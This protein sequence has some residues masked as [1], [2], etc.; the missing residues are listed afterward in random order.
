[1]NNSSFPSQNFAKAGNTPAYESSFSPMPS[2]ASQ[3]MQ[4]FNARQA[5]PPATSPT[6]M[7]SSRNFQPSHGH[8]QSTSVLLNS[9]SRQMY[10]PQ[11]Q[12]Q[13][14]QNA[15]S[16]NRSTSMRPMSAFQPLDNLDYYAAGGG[17]S[18]PT[19]Q[20]APSPTGSTARS[21]RSTPQTPLTF[22][23]QDLRSA[24]SLQESQQK[25]LYM[26]GYLLKRD[27]LGTDGKPLH[28]ADEKRRWSE[29][30]V[31]LSGTVLSLWN[32]EQMQDAARRGT[33]VPPT[34]IN[35]TDSFVDFIGLLIEDPKLIPG[36][37]GRY[38]HA[39]AINSAGNNRTIFCF[40][41]PPPFPPESL[42]QWLAPEH[43]HKPEHRTVIGWL[44][45][46][47]RHL[48][49]WIN[50]IRLA[51]WEKVRLE[52]IYT[53]ALIRA[54]LGAVGSP[55]NSTPDGIK[56]PSS[57]NAAE[58]SIKSPLVKGKMEGW[59][60]ARFMGSTE[61]KKVWMVLTD[62]KPD[63][64]EF[65][66]KKFWK[67][68]SSGDRS[69][70]MSISGVSTAAPGAP[71]NDGKDLPP[72]P[73]SN[74][75][76]GV[77][78][79][80]ESKKDKKPFA[81][82]IYAAH[83][84]AVY[85]SRPELVEG[86]S[87]FK[88]EGVFPSSSVLSA[89][90]RVRTTGWVMLMPELDTA[91]SKGANAE[92]M[93]WLIAFMDSFKLYGRPD[94]LVWEARDPVSPFFA[95][96]IG[97]FKDR[98]FLDRELAEFLEIARE[99]HLTT[100]ASLHGIMAARMRGERTKILQPL[101][102][103]SQNTGASTSKAASLADEEPRTA[104]RASA[105][106]S[107]SQLPPLNFDSAQRQPTAAAAPMV[108]NVSNT[109]HRSSDQI[110]RVS[111]AFKD[112]ARG[113][114]TDKESE[115]AASPDFDSFR[116]PREARPGQTVST[117]PAALQPAPTASAQ[118]ATPTPAALVAAAPLNN[119][120]AAPQPARAPVVSQLSTVPQSR[121]QQDERSSIRA[122]PS[123]TS[124][125]PP[126]TQ[127]LQ[128]A[129]QTAPATES[130]LAYLTPS[131]ANAS[132]AMPP[133]PE[134]DAAASRPAAVFGPSGRGAEQTAPEQPRSTK[135]DSDLPTNYDESAL[136]FM[137]SISDQ[138][139]ATSSQP[140]V[141]PA[142]SRNV[143]TKES[144]QA[145][146]PQSLAPA[147]G[148][149]SAIQSESTHATRLSSDQQQQSA[150]AAAPAQNE[151]AKA[152]P[153]A[154]SR[155]NPTQ[156]DTINDDAL[157][158]Y[159]FLEQPPSPALR[160]KEAP[161]VKTNEVERS[162]V[163]TPVAAAPVQPAST[164]VPQTSVDSNFGVRPSAVQY[165]S[166]F[167]QNKRA[168]ERKSAAQLQAQA[169]QEALSRPGRAGANKPKGMRR[170]GW[171][172]DS[173]EEEEEEEDDEEEE[174]ER[175][176]RIV[177]SAGA[178]RSAASSSRGAPGTESPVNLADSVGSLG[179][180]NEAA[181]QAAA[182][183]FPRSVSGYGASVVG[184]S[185]SDSP[186]QSP[187]RGA[188]PTHP[189]IQ[190]YQRQSMFNSH[191]AAAHGD[192]SRSNT[193]P[194]GPIVRDRQTFLQLNP[195]EQP[196]AMTTVFTPHGLVQAGAQDKAERSAK[197]Q[198]AEARATGR[199]LVNVPNKPPPPQAGLLGAI[200]AHE[201]DRKGAGG[202]GATL[203]ERERERVAAERRQ[204]EED[205]LRQQQ[206]QVQQQQQMQQMQQMAYFNP[207]MYQQMMMSGM[208]GGMGMM[209][210]GMPQMGGFGGSQ[211]G[212]G[213]GSQMGGMGGAFDP[214]MAQQQAV[215]AAQMAY[216]NA[217]SQAHQE[218]SALGHGSMMG[219]GSPG[220][221]PAS[222]MGMPMGSMP[223]MASPHM[224]MMGLPYPGFTAPSAMGGA[225]SPSEFNAGAGG[226]S[227][228]PRS[229]SGK[230]NG[231]GNA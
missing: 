115:R 231:Q 12:Q 165:P 189:S 160:T 206:Q 183:N 18:S 192:D 51:S 201:R 128:P 26:E 187:A 15:S 55:G 58:M 131:N 222:T 173:E 96:P 72:P 21:I 8:S 25:K 44:N 208:M 214:M 179:R 93:K 130:S 209:G 211:M 125:V 203:T 158:A 107:A 98:L 54:R 169:H 226:T 56:D 4:P 197:A 159:S 184:G 216:M 185:R 101:P 217:L 127:G 112:S 2:S 123:P 200:T 142:P 114:A 5:A 172:D 30:F 74:G 85:P 90:H 157:A 147:S 83:A 181:S 170:P 13:Q 17:A 166:T 223:F 162:S 100:R 116:P 212:G 3:N 139:P 153:S 198:E 62:H 6:T 193:P 86:S 73:G 27:D 161:V 224:S 46:G 168:A 31:Q 146:R 37:R 174:E 40:R 52:E 207:M 137:A 199:N 70:V 149:T 221:T 97:P 103:P 220:A 11:S 91:G 145:S 78:S 33:E 105:A 225:A 67:L 47:H 195:E 164:A 79:F 163:P 213:G 126:P 155:T 117:H 108:Q 65:G 219:H 111:N 113:D 22:K 118:A 140:V 35:I 104:S 76:P 177:P 77:A 99:D 7:A 48:Q 110:G 66:K 59:V 202:F 42:E 71:S 135:R 218:G 129:L 150:A 154:A 167:G 16:G 24:L 92:M 14:Q 53:G 29:C 190:A 57:V 171:V 64:S 87:L 191:L 88:I 188:I 36:S 229:P 60:K 204:R 61:W 82:L 178:A 19:L 109:S 43:R 228:L 194:Q 215:Q 182:G 122:V 75:A 102:P 227:P 210:M 175:P 143:V 151:L 205:A 80:F 69:S 63:E 34:Y 81:T 230:P 120:G 176:S 141:M 148:T 136:F 180:G 1:M 84:F 39:F 45:L 23:S 138:L 124:A 121:D 50:A 186:G 132:Q 20:R 32:V 95:Y 41:D 106:E 119:A 9:S 152:E 49:A 133:A 10:R 144:S 68:G 196:G 89:T 38:H 28:V 156:D 134:L 94:T